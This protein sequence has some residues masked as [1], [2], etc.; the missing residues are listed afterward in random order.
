MLPLLALLA[1]TAAAAP[2]ECSPRWEREGLHICRESGSDTATLERIG[3]FSVVPALCFAWKDLTG[4]GKTPVPAIP[5][6]NEYE[7]DE[8]SAA[9][10]PSVLAWGRSE[11][12]AFVVDPR[13]VKLLPASGTLT[14]DPMFLVPSR[15]VGSNLRTASSRPRLPTSA[16]WGKGRWIR[17]PRIVPGVGTMAVSLRIGGFL[18]SLRV[19][20]AV[21]E[22]DGWRLGNGPHV[23]QW[24][25]NEFV[26]RIDTLKGMATLHQASLSDTARGYAKDG[27]RDTHRMVM[28]G[29]LRWVTRTLGS[30]GRIT[31]GQLRMDTVRLGDSRVI[32]ALV[33]P[34]GTAL[35][36][37]LLDTMRV[38][39]R[40]FLVLSASPGTRVI[41]G[42]PVLDGP[43]T[44][45]LSLD[46]DSRTRRDILGID[47]LK[48]RTFALR[49]VGDS[50]RRASSDLRLSYRDGDAL[51][52]GRAD[53]ELARPVN[54]GGRPYLQAVF[55]SV[56]LTIP[57]L[58]DTSGN[59]AE[60][61]MTLPRLRYATWGAQD[62]LKRQWPRHQWSDSTSPLNW[63]FYPVLRRVPDFTVYAESLQVAWK[64]GTFVPMPQEPITFQSL[65]KR[66]NSRFR[67]PTL[68]PLPAPLDIGTPW[69]GLGRFA[70]ATHVRLAENL[71]IQTKLQ[72]APAWARML[73]NRPVPV[74]LPA[75]PQRDA[76]GHWFATVREQPAFGLRIATRDLLPFAAALPRD[77]ED[78]LA[79]E[80][81][82]RNLRLQARL[83]DA[84]R[85]PDFYQPLV[86]RRFPDF[87]DGTAR[88]QSLEWSGKADGSPDTARETW[89]MLKRPL[90]MRLGDR[91]TVRAQEPLKV[92]LWTRPSGN[93]TTVRGQ[94]MTRFEG[95]RIVQSPG[96]SLLHLDARNR[97]VAPTAPAPLAPREGRLALTIK[98]GKVL[99]VDRT[100]VTNERYRA[101]VKAGACQEPNPAC[102]A[103]TS[104]DGRSDSL[105]AVRKALW[106]AL[107]DMPATCLEPAQ[108]MTFCRWSH[109]RLPS[110]SEFSAI[111]RIVTDSI[112]LAS[113][114]G[115]AFWPV[116]RT[117]GNRHSVRS[118][119]GGLLLAGS[120]RPMP[121]GI[122]DLAGNAEEYCLRG[123]TWGDSGRFS[124]VLTDSTESP[125]GINPQYVG[126]R[127]VED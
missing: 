88:L 27:L 34:S 40:P 45:T 1:G 110:F 98:G 18:S 8:T 100:E 124:C 106:H 69:P 17:A 104:S 10:Q 58:N 47:T 21:L 12:F 7:D 85:L 19:D 92:T 87:P 103:A 99:K 122:Y 46:P 35:E 41:R 48:Q 38:S 50:G 63:R 102:G 82:E 101:C 66:F 70:P 96:D 59:P 68:I 33:T 119:S 116:H 49:S 16:T 26:E 51:V 121:P 13:Q 95:E 89:E 15:S 120:L 64:G 80:S 53:V 97:P 78:T 72:P 83:D 105:R 111:G 94:E 112:D 117:G 4:Q 20:S 25:E 125:R 43:G 71:Q 9:S 91:S 42:L 84:D 127:C 79:L 22:A 118:G 56:L 86:L 44:R 123:G 36:G 75:T 30:S 73:G 76:Q 28:E 115:S 5:L 3:D 81:P 32:D 29:E 11:T 57:C 37:T 24:L 61:R 77:M 65:Q 55:D 60:I 107:P 31:A 109:G 14:L 62:T 52:T 54:A 67:T 6:R 113:S 2:P 114:F 23:I 90:E 39:L 74:S 126:F 93:R 108:A